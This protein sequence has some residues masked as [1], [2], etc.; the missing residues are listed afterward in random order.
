MHADD[1]DIRPPP[2]RT[3]D[4]A[5][6]GIG[7][8]PMAVVKV[9]ATVLG[10]ALVVRLVDPALLAAKVRAI[11][12]PTFVLGAS[13]MACQIPLVALRWGII[14]DAMNRER[15]PVPRAGSF[16]RITYVAQFFGQ[17]LPSLA[18][19][20]VRVLMLRAAGPSLRIAFKSTLLDRVTAA[21]AL[22][23]LALPTVTLSP[24][25]ASIR[26]Y[27]APGAALIGLGLAVAAAVILGADALHLIG[28]RWRY[29]GA[30]TETVV[31]LRAILAS[32]AH[33]PA[34]VMLCFAVHGLS[35]L[36]FWL[37]ARGQGLHFG[38]QDAI[39]IVPLVLL[40]SLVPLAVGG[41]GLREGFVVWL[42]GTG[43]IG[44]EDALLLSV[45]FGT[46]VLLSTLPG[47]AALA[48]GAWSPSR[49]TA[50]AAGKVPC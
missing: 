22:L 43:G 30:V 36:A 40:V 37:L 13:L 48:V 3:P 16:L 35:V 23:A 5:R 34:V 28:R 6:A 2:S 50:P 18:G 44:R 47:L 25:L 21:L 7:R 9:A 27:L 26:P 31:D 20:G 32:R 39:A 33:G 19:D 15:G 4:G 42:L 49:P 46:A 38:L 11:D 1:T 14:V 45:S 29:A 8:R 17:I 41:W 12:V 24:I 10:L